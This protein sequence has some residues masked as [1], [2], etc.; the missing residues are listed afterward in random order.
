MDT[1]NVFDPNNLNTIQS[2]SKDNQFGRVSDIEKIGD[3][4]YVSDEYKG[5]HH[6]NTNNGSVFSFEN[7]DVMSL[8]FLNNKIT[9]LGIWAGL[10][11]YD[12]NDPSAPNNLNYTLDVYTDIDIASYPHTT[13][14]FHSWI[15]NNGTSHFVANISDSK[16][17]RVEENTNGYSVVT[18]LDLL[19]YATAFTI[20]GNYEFITTSASTAAPLQTSFD[21]ITMVDLTTMTVVDSHTLNNA[22]GVAVK[23]GIAYV[24]AANGLH[25]YDT[26]FGNL[27]LINTF[28]QGF[29]SYISIN[30]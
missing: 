9:C 7:H 2:I 15:R 10:Y 13:G 29:G 28:P 26:S 11:G 23:A 30:N 22:S 20:E 27:N 24:T 8:S 1:Y 4:I 14:S 12:V 19:G 5:I 3:Y 21:R 25:I 17:K 18:E 6:I 16:L